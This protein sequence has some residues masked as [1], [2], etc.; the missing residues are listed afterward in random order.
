MLY[1]RIVRDRMWFLIFLTSSATHAQSP[2]SVE[3]GKGDAGAKD[4][5]P[6]LE[7]SKV[8]VAAEEPYDPKTR[9]RR[10]LR[11]KNEDFNEVRYDVVR[12]MLGPQLWVA[13]GMYFLEDG[14]PRFALLGAFAY[15]FDVGPFVLA[16]GISPTIR[17]PRD[18]VTAT[19]LLTFRVG[20]PIHIVY[21]FYEIGIGPTFATA[22]LNL[23]ATATLANT[24]GVYFYVLPG[25]GLGVRAAY[26]HYL[27]WE[28]GNWGISPVFDFWL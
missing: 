11:L 6:L 3:P 1:A 12:R 21:P 18:G 19:G 4:A 25:F 5:A 13:P 14:T 20:V 16:P 7:D 24:I 22:T 2:P 28:Q 9:I 23:P 26:T 15:G 17:F 27:A 10:R 8:E